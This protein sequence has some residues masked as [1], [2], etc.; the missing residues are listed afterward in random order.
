M[1][2]CQWDPP[3]EADGQPLCDDPSTIRVVYRDGSSAYMC[4]GHTIGMLD[5][6][7]HVEDMHG[8]T[9]ADPAVCPALTS[10]VVD[11]D[12]ETDVCGTYAVQT[13]SGVVHCYAGHITRPKTAVSGTSTQ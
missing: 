2:T 1:L 8:R 12:V 10:V 5:G 13:I 4:D 11:G 6:A 9:L 7:D 3:Y